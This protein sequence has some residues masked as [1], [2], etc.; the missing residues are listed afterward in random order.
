M[1]QE[2]QRE[3]IVKLE[4]LDGKTWEELVDFM[5][6]NRHALVLE[7]TPHEIET[8]K[9]ADDNAEAGA[10]VAIAYRFLEKY[11]APRT[12]WKAADIY[13][14]LTPKSDD[15]LNL[16]VSLA[17]VRGANNTLTWPI[18]PVPEEEE[19]EG[20]LANVMFAVAAVD[21]FD[22]TSSEKLA[23]FAIAKFLDDG[24]KKKREHAEAV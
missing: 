19:K 3:G 9:T 10:A 6:V 2:I 24:I 1:V 11:G 23:A 5:K 16:Q 4:R 22:G 21:M 15:L 17:W 18:G 8:A 20:G 12:A 7:E 14:R 13:K